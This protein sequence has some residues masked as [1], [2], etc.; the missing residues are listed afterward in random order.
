M[1]GGI[2]PRSAGVG[3]R[4]GGFWPGRG[5]ARHRSE[6]GAAAGAA[7]SASRE[8]GVEGVLPSHQKVQVGIRE[9]AEVVAEGDREG[10]AVQ[11][12]VIGRGMAGVDATGVLTHSGIAAMMVG[13]LDRPVPAT[14]SASGRRVAGHRHRP[15]QPGQLRQRTQRQHGLY[16]GL[17]PLAAAG[18]RHLR[19]QVPQRPHEPLLADA[20]RAG[21]ATVVPCEPLGES[22]RNPVR[23]PVAGAPESRWIHERLCQLQR[24]PVPC[25]PAPG[26][27]L[28]AL[29]QD[30]RR[31]I[32]NPRRLRQHQEPCVVADPMQPPE[33][34][35][36]VPAQQCQ[37]IALPNRD[38]PQAAACE[39]LESEVMVLVYPRIPTPALVRPYRTHFYL[40]DWYCGWGKIFGHGRHD[41]PSQQK[42]S[43]RSH[44]V[45]H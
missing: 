38:L 16:T 31:P 42:K 9:P 15:R 39:L 33:R 2:P 5:A 32:R 43:V 17:A 22:H 18:V 11:G 14:L 29:P 28:P 37:P 41:K 6:G 20:V 4:V 10:D 27:S 40:P 23:R 1:T 12:G 21:V 7:P 44:A 8:E 35:R 26:Q 3:E 19:K 36:A 13:I 34:H 24:V 25:Q 30:P 45:D